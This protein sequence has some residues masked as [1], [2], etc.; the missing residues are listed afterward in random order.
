MNLYVGNLAPDTTREEIL[1]AFQPHGEVSSVS[2]PSQGMNA[3]R[4]TGPARG[5]AFV[6]MQDKAQALAALQALHL[7]DLHGRP[8]TVQ[9]AREAQGRRPR[10]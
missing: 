1:K 2:L 9:A 3:G 8:M 5:Y 10:R 6:V 7:R 4:A